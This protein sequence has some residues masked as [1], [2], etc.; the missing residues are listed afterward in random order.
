MNP[1]PSP[2]TPSLLAPLLRP[3]Q[4]FFSAE[5]AGGILLLLGTIAALG[6]ANSPWGESYHHFWHTPLS[7][8][9]GGSTYAMSLGHWVNDGLMVIFFLLVGLEIKRELLVGELASVRSAALPIAAAIGGMAV[10]ALIYV[11]LNAGGA[12]SAGWGIPMATDIAFAVGVLAVV[13]RRL[14]VS[15]KVLLLAVAIVDDLG[16]VLVIA[17]FYT[18]E[19]SLTAL[20]VAGGF[21]AALIT[22]NVLR[23]HKPFPYLVLGIGLWAATVASGVHATVA[24]V[25]LACT[26]PASR[27]IEELPYL[28]YVRRM[29]KVFERDVAATPDQITE[30]QSYALQAM[31]KATQA[32]QTP[33]TRIEYAL[34][35]PVN[36]IVVPLFALANAGLDLRSGGAAAM[37]SPIAWGVLLGLLLGKPLGILAASW[38]AVKT[39][40]AELPEGATWRQVSGIAV[41]CGLG[42][43]MSLFVANLAFPVDPAALG[44]AKL[45]VL[46]ASAIAGIAGG[47]LI[48]GAGRS[49][50]VQPDAT[51]P[52]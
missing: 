37:M 50:K 40:I 22:L 3:I 28:E 26:I 48:F 36:F 30:S 21:L 10:P 17:L 11:L 8:S 41:L 45:G 4:A 25:L 20:S 44:A 31:E 18:G 6:W 16:A 7:V 1:D 27:Q 5:S 32:V 2:V 49:A 52:A 51:E 39:G 14:P 29:L 42:F 23:V 24:G 15:V 46:V 43:T 9:F 47:A 33:L 38:V 12:G 19:I 34:L 35:R 13:G